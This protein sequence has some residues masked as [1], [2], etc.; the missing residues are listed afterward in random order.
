[1]NFKV[2]N[3]TNLFYPDSEGKRCVEDCEVGGNATNGGICGGIV[4]ESWMQLYD[5]AA[6]CCAEKLSSLGEHCVVLSGEL[7]AR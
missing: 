5:D 4:E 6:A 7:T 2:F 3:G 1:M